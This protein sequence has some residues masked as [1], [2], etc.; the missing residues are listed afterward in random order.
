MSEPVALRIPRAGRRSWRR[1]SVRRTAR[2]AAVSA[3]SAVLALL[4]ALGGWR[5]YSEWRLG[6]IEL[7]NDGPMLTVQVLDESG[8]HPL[9]EPVEVFKKATLSLPDGDYRLRVNQ[10]GRLGRT[11]RFGVHRGETI[12]HPLSLD[13]GRLLGRELDPSQFVVRDQPPEVPMPFALV[14]AALELTPGKADIVEFTGKTVIRRDGATGT[15]VW[16]AAN[17]T[18]P[19]DPGR[20]PALWLRRIGPNRW[21]FA[22]AEPAVDLDGDGTRDVLVVATRNRAFLALSGKDGSMLWNHVAQDD[23]SG[24][25]RPEGPEL[26]GPI[27][28]ASRP[29]GLIGLP[30][31]EDVDGDGTPDVIATMV[32]REFEAEA[33]RRLGTPTGDRTDFLVR[34]MVQAISGRSGR[35]IWT[36]PIDPTYANPTIQFGDKPAVLTRG[37]RSSAVVVPDGM[38]W[39]ALDPKTGRPK[40]GPIDLGF[41]PV[42][43]LQYADLDGDREPDIVALGPG[44][45]PKQQSLAAFST[46]TGRPLWTATVAATYQNPNDRPLPKGWP[47]LVDL[48]GD[49]RTEVIV[50][51]S[52]PVPPRAGYRGVK[53]FDG[54]SG[55]TRWVRPMS[56]ETTADDGPDHLLEAPDLDGDGV[57]DLIV[58]SHFD[59]RQPPASR[60]ENRSEPARAYVDAL[61]GRDGRLLWC[62]HADL[63]EGKTAHI[64]PP[65]WWGR[66]PDGWPALAIPLGGQN[67][68]ESGWPSRA[69]YFHPP[70]VHV[71][72]A[73]TGRERNR[74]VGLGRVGVCDLDGDGLIDL[75]GEAE[76]RLQAFRGEPPEAWRTLG[77]F[78]PTRRTDQPREGSGHRPAADLDGDGIADTLSDGLDYPGASW[79]RW[80]GSRTAIA[81][82]GR[83]GRMLWKATLDPARLWFWPEPVRS[84][85][86]AAYPPPAGDL[87]GDGTPDVIVK[88]FSNDPAAIG[89]E[90]VSL[91][92][93]ALSGRDGRPLWTAGP[94]PLGFEAH[95][96]T[97]VQWFEPRTLRPGAPPDL[98][99][100]HLNPFLTPTATP[101]RPS[102][103][104]PVQ[105]RL[106][107]VSGRTGRVVW[108]V[109]VVEKP[110]YPWARWDVPLKIADLDGDGGPDAALT[111]RQVVGD[112][113]WAF[114]LRAISLRDGKNIWS[115]ILRY[116]GYRPEFPTIEIGEGGK[117]EPATVYAPELPTRPTANDLLVHALDGRDGTIRW[118]WRS[119]GSEGNYWAR[120]VIKLIDLD[121]KGKDSIC[122]TY[123]D[124]QS[125]THIVLLDPHG[126]EHARRVLPPERVPTDYSPPVAD[127]MVDLDGDGRDELLVWYD[128]RRAAWGRDLREIW[129]RPAQSWSIGP[130]L[131]ST[132]GR[133]RTLIIEP[134][135]GLDGS[136]GR[137]LWTYKAP[138]WEGATLLDPGDSGRMP[139]VI[140]AGLYSGRTV[141]RQVLPATPEGDYQRPSG[142]LV[143]AGQVPDDPRWTRPLPWTG[144]VR[145]VAAP[146]WVFALVGLALVNVVLPIA[147]LRLAARRRPWTIR[148]LMMLP[149]AAA[150]PLCCYL[151]VEPL[152]PVQVEPLPPYPRLL[153]ALATLAGLP[154]V[155]LAA[156]AGWGLV[157]LRW[158]RLG[159]LVALT[160]LA[161]AAIAAAWLYL[162]GRAMPAIEHYG[163]SGCYLVLVPGAY[164][165]GLLILIEWPMR[166]AYRWLKHPRPIEPGIPSTS[167]ERR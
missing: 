55:R 16:D 102:S 15:V 164:V 82:S 93:Q 122:V 14:T 36:Y 7:T 140:S 47:W 162:D 25:P 144:P 133:P 77:S 30:A 108:D 75:W 53:M 73:S 48:D 113:Q 110:S 54:P 95:G 62:W 20:D 41:E 134:M 76:G 96:Q 154:V 137:V 11:Y 131:P 9:G 46:A 45:G 34:R 141:C 4:A 42:R 68:D 158:K 79:S 117:G 18:S 111:V 116:E 89:R 86:L 49:G 115:R 146:S 152:M 143:P 128:R 130:F 23:G 72:E 123:G 29:G 8:E 19:H 56:P 90:P 159:A 91:P 70:A 155:A 153:F 125:G 85:D 27:E 64:W 33:E 74:A 51:D 119:G 10:E 163:R 142:S 43:P 135:T 129:S 58:V 147:M 1:R 99:V 63:A 139:R 28:P 92:I 145:R 2:I 132:P 156:L 160:A 84:Y 87:D 24:G 44:P 114:E 3:A 150:V 66:G 31:I 17:P 81:R 71:L 161:S 69:E 124:R 37:R 94:I 67:P 65:R 149:L 101:T 97:W 32:F 120:G 151:A 22:V 107:Q 88:K 80:K 26:P 78:A 52:G 40:A 166:G 5:A 105:E 39:L 109:P 98:L 112:D 6:R 104:A 21:N 126:K 38:R 157:R 12:A 127:V 103:G 60:A 138:H 35:W 13:E 83:D 167:T 106:A 59:G 50:P 61:S 57:R 121:G 118:T 100:L 136:T 148:L 165:A